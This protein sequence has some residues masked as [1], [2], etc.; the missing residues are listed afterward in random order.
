MTVSFSMDP[1]ATA[2]ASAIGA[3]GRAGHRPS[4]SACPRRCLT[5]GAVRGPRD[6]HDIRSHGSLHL[7][8]LPAVRRVARHGILAPKRLRVLV[9]RRA[10]HEDIAAVCPRHQAIAGGREA[11][12]IDRSGVA[13]K[14]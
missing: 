12:N 10:P 6:V 13:G 9:R 8:G 14:L 3:E 1:A 2:G 4:A 7:D 5:R 11:H